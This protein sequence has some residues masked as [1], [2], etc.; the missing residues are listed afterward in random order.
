[1]DLRV[2]GHD[3][4]MKELLMS[5]PKWLWVVVGVSS[6]VACSATQPSTS[7]TSAAGDDAGA[8][9]AAGQ[10]AAGGGGGTT[11]SPDSGSSVTVPELDAGADVTPSCGSFDLTYTVTKGNVLVLF[12]Q[13]NSM[14][15]PWDNGLP[16]WRVAKEAL[17]AALADFKSTLD[18]GTLFFPSTVGPGMPKSGAANCLEGWVEP[19]NQPPQIPLVDTPAFLVTFAAHFGPAFSTI[20]TT[21]IP[22]TLELAVEALPDPAPM[23]GKRIVVL[24]SDGG[25]TCGADDLDEPLTELASRGIPLWVIGLPGSASSADTLNL[26]A[27]LG[28]TKAPLTPSNGE[29]LK[30]AFASAV[31]TSIDQCAFTFDPPPPALDD[32]HLI[33]T[34]STTPG[35]YEIE[36][37]S[38]WELAPDGKTV[39]LT[40]ELCDKVKSAQFDSV[41]FIFGCPE[42]V[43]E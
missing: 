17:E 42:S 6:I 33:V 16:R 11:V 2:S 13:S 5:T 35:G 1:M 32:V 28:G 21:P 18:V 9:N 34:D 4:E 15:K 25:T 3:P 23:P 12:D 26:L 7:A 10:T 24:L 38:G 37:S 29:A 19:I 31:E 30:D 8:G 39:T 20:N 27:T 40:G 43:I 36:P 22:P 14:K 41:K